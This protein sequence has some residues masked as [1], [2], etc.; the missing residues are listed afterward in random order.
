MTVRGVVRPVPGLRRK[1]LLAA[2]ALHAG[3]TVST[4]RLIDIVWDGKPPSTAA[5]SLQRHV[6]YLR[7]DHDVRKAIAA[8]SHGYVLDLP[9]EATDVEGAERL[10]RESRQSGDL[11]RSA[12]RLRD[13]LALWRGRPLADVSGL[14]WMNEQAENLTRIELAAIRALI[15]ARLALGEHALLIPELESLTHHHPYHE[16]T[17][18]QL[19]LALYRSGRQAEALTAYQRLRAKLA[20]DLG[21]DP[22]RA[23]RDLQVAILRQD[24]ALDPPVAPVSLAPAPLAG[25]VPTQLPVAVRSFAPLVVSE[26]AH[27]LI[28]DLLTTEEARD[29]LVQ[30][31]G[32][33]RVAAELHQATD[34]PDPDLN[35]SR[36]GDPATMLEREAL[37]ASLDV[38]LAAAATGRGSLVVLGGEAGVGKST[39]AEAFCDRHRGRVV[40]AWGACDA[41]Q[42]PR[43]LGPVH[44]VARVVGGRLAEVIAAAEARHTIF[45][46]LLDALTPP[47]SPMVMVI[48]DV[49]WADEATLDLLIFLGRRV[50]RTRAVVLATFRNDEVGPDHPFRAV[51]GN[52]ATASGVRRLEVPPLSKAAVGEL[53]SPYDVEPDQL[54]EVTGGNP[55]FVT[56]ILGALVPT[57]SVPTS[58]SDAVLSRVGRLSPAARKAVDTAAIIPGRVEIALLRAVTGAGDDDIDTCQQAGVLLGDGTGLRFRHELARL[59]VEQALPAARRTAVHAAV[60]AYISTQPGTDVDRLAH[61]AEEAGVA[62]AVQVHAARAAERAAKL[63]AHREAAAQYARMLR[64]ADGL[65]PPRRTR[66][67]RA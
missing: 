62:D 52:L 23:L 65:P 60:L 8:R 30:R 66:A 3:H 14:S 64:F 51:L 28:L 44:D 25:A 37:M 24:S 31:L 10:I 18:H 9:G 2:L 54:F 46:A 36:S 43:P 63:G 34:G 15:D 4:D 32:A 41:M 55:F 50:T 6:S 48:E 20:E 12:S 1:A 38:R 22:N 11:A 7:G 56:E 13:A 35:P 21:V 33:G 59:A 39:L 27:P 42:T 67:R 19:M 40:V 49:H 16:Q 5:N 58:V 57:P 53:A 61:H 26:G 29:L 45:M 47:R 17:H